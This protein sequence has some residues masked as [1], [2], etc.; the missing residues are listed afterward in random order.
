MTAAA[1]LMAD[2]KVPAVV[3]KETN[4]AYIRAFKARSGPQVQTKL[5]TPV[6]VQNDWA[7]KN[8]WDTAAAQTWRALAEKFKYTIDTGD[9][10]AVDLMFE[11]LALAEK[12]DAHPIG[13]IH[14]ARTAMGRPVWDR[15]T[16][17]FM[18]AN[19]VASEDEVDEDYNPN[20]SSQEAY[21]IDDD[22]SAS[23]TS[24][25]KKRKSQE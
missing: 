5:P 23:S 21:E 1:A 22:Q 17:E 6:S 9:G 20:P 8:G 11:T 25:A 18:K 12:C 19:L 16:V 15:D 13:I 2:F 14:H 3:N 4:Q 10:S 24:K 7:I